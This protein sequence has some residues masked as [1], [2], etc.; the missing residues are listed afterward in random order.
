MAFSS[1]GHTIVLDGDVAA[2]AAY[3]QDTPLGTSAGIVH[4]FNRGPT[5][6]ALVQSLQG[7]G[8]IQQKRFGWD[9]ALQDT[10]LLIGSP[11]DFVPGNSVGG[12][13]YRFELVGGQWEQQEYLIQNTTFF[14]K[15]VGLSGDV[16]AVGAPRDNEL[17]VDAG[18]AWVYRM[19]PYRTGYCTA[20]TSAS[21]C[22]ALISASGLPSATAATGFHLSVEDVEGQ[23][24]GLFFWGSSGRQSNPWAGST[25]FLCVAPPTT[26][27]PVLSGSG[28]AQACGGAASFDL[29]ARWTAK[30]AQNPGAGSV[31]QAQFWYRDPQA[32]AS[33]R[34]SLSD[35]VEFT[36][37]P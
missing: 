28:T 11:Q 2:V 4:I 20:G 10:R 32:A 9:L 8:A 25:S 3:S 5:D 34:T 29:N 36:V 17:G 16:I 24:S 12:S 33:A 23:K 26:R 14:G 21:G 6:W 30:P 13:V 27:G 7:T 1:F 22:S 35:A 19:A 37:C 18:A 15:G 31:V